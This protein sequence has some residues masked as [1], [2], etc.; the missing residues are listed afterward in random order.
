LEKWKFCLFIF[1]KR[2]KAKLDEFEGSQRFAKNNTNE[3]IKV[4]GKN[5]VP[6]F[7]SGRR[8]RFIGSGARPAPDE[9]ADG[10]SATQTFLLEDA[11]KFFKKRIIYGED[12][13]DPL[14]IRYILFRVSKFGV[15]LHKFCRSDHERC[16]HDHP[17]NFVSII[18]KGGYQ[19][20]TNDGIVRYAPGSILVRPCEWRHR[21]EMFFETIDQEYLWQLFLELDRVLKLDGHLYMFCDDRVAPILLHWIRE[22]GDEHRFGDAH[23]LIW[24]KVSM[25]MGYH[26]RRRYEC[27]V[28]AWRE[29][30]EGVRGFQKRKRIGDTLLDPF[31][32]SGVLAAA[33]PFDYNA[34]ILLNDKF[35][36]SMAYMRDVTFG[37]LKAQ[38]VNLEWHNPVFVGKVLEIREPREGDFDV[39]DE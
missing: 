34:T 38:M 6:G 16:L 15:F 33:T 5:A 11:M 3:S 1:P 7:S 25:G 20:V 32:G 17:W 36:A 35:E 37:G 27:I 14:M 28:F 22:A 10:R 23:M 4:L 9:V 30:R 13:S 29:P 8:R 26:Y 19:E 18:L 21:D 2:K 24:D 39:L 31:A 12:P